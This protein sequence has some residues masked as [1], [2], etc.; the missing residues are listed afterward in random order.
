M[1]SMFNCGGGKPLYPTKPRLH[2]LA[3]GT[4]LYSD[5]AKSEHRH[6]Y[7]SGDVTCQLECY[8][9]DGLQYHLEY[10]GE[11]DLSLT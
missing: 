8:L 10:R 3:L 11:R 2:E 1:I 7:A 9:R 4:R 6:D 5:Q